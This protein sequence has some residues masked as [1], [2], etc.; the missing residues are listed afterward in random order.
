MGVNKKNKIIIIFIII[1]IIIIIVCLFYYLLNYYEYYE[2]YEY[3][4]DISSKKE[5]INNKKNINNEESVEENV[6]E[7]SGECNARNDIV[8]FCINYNKCCSDKSTT[9]AC[10]CEHPFI[11]KCR[12]EFESCLDNPEHIKLY[13]KKIV[14]E[15]CLE[16]NEKCCIPYNSLS[17]SNTNFKSPIKNNPE[18]NIICS[19]I[20]TPNAEEKC[21]E[22]CNTNPECKAYS[23]DK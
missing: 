12:S 11:K 21:L 1:I 5:I 23:L 7:P 19:L 17:I 2:Y 22:L 16:K 3:Y 18:H 15:K 4:K 9:K 6:E 8:D 14:M 20:G 10:F 13:G